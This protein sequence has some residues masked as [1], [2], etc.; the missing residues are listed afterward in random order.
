MP[1]GDAIAAAPS[2]AVKIRA[3]RARLSQVLFPQAP[4]TKSP[5]RGWEATVLVVALLTI[6]VILQLLRLGWSASLD[7]VWAEDGP[8]F[9]QGAL[10]Q[11]I[12]DSAF[13]PYAE[14]LV[15][16]SRLIVETSTMLP[17][18]Y[19]PAG[20]S[21]LSATVVALS[22][23]AVWHASAGHIENPY[24]RGTLACLTV[25]T[26]VAGAESIDSATYVPWYMLF[27]TFWLLLWR[28]RTA[29]GA[30]LG[31][32]FVLLTALT[33][34]G[35]WLLAP[36]AALRAV[37]IR[38]RRD[39]AIVACFGI[40]AAIQVPV[41][42]LHSEQGAEPTWT[43]D[44][45]TAY[46]QRVIDGGALGERLGGLAWAHLG[47]PFLVL[48]LL[49]A[50]AGLGLGIKRSASRG[51]GLAAIAIPTSL[52]MF[53]VSAY[54]RQVGTALMWPAGD[55]SGVSSRYVIVPALLLASAAL[56]LL[57]SS[58]RRGA[59]RERPWA[60]AAAVVVLLL[61]IATSFSAR[62]AVRQTPR[63][64]D[65]L[66]RAATSCTRERLPEAPVATS[67]P[68]FGVQL[69]CERIASFADAPR[70]R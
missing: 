28:P 7:S 27:A 35:V 51:R 34:P 61:G 59:G 49:S 30:L 70:R 52:V 23:L 40:G 46:L 3:F 57:D 41:V 39:L 2:A 65:A 21:I 58:S 13:V 6:A 47:W 36:L 5:L 43:S 54:Q 69:P 12:W 9:L 38:D 31:S 26:P 37:A 14:Y 48:L 66:E 68:G 55:Y 18:Q 1:A 10:T 32:L 50:V 44:I 20:I 17:L 56:A 53:V 16:A 62:D 15:L 24:L 63:W 64:V 42:A 45:W 8:V 33:T 11:S 67:P 60:G 4:S 29:G 22:G 25:L 19:V